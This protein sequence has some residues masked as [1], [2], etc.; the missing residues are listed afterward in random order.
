MSNDSNESYV[1]A[2]C[3][4]CRKP[5]LEL[6]PS[7]RHL[8]TL[9]ETG[10]DYCETTGV[11]IPLD[12]PETLRQALSLLVSE[13]SAFG[14]EIFRVFDLESLAYAD[15]P[16]IS[17]PSVCVRVR[18][19]TGL[20]RARQRPERKGLRRR[21]KPS[22]LEWLSDELDE[23]VTEMP[24]YEGASWSRIGEMVA[25]RLSCATADCSTAITGYRDIERGYPGFGSNVTYVW[26]KPRMK[27][28]RAI[29]AALRRDARDVRSCARRV[30]K[31]PAVTLRP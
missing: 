7:C 16:A 25:S 6:E 27:T 28:A 18:Q 31:L 21:A 11:D 3:E 23:F 15:A 12:T 9:F 17:M 14:S 26:G 19:A 10:W 20:E 22:R 13:L 24:D 1:D 30:A 4:F 29:A 8:V 2:Y 5:I